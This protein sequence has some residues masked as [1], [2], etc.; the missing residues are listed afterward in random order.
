IAQAGFTLV[1]LAIVLL[2]VGL[3]ISG[4][5]KGQELIQNSRTT[6]TIQQTK[7]YEAAVNTFRDSF[8][9]L[10]GDLINALDRVPGCTA[11]NVNCANG[12]G[13][14]RVGA[15]NGAGTAS[16]ATVADERGRFWQ[17]LA[18]ANLIS[19][20]IPNFTATAP[21]WG[22]NLP[23]GRLTGGF[24]IGQANLAAG[25]A[26][27]NAG[28]MNGHYLTMQA[29]PND[30]TASATNAA[31]EPGRAAQIDLKLDD[32]QPGTGDVVALGN[33]ATCSSLNTPAG[34]YVSATETAT[35]NI[36]IKILN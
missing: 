25:G 11:A 30:T 29:I 28:P 22:T 4:I 5:L 19:G 27:G 36:A 21:A 31:V 24:L 26:P 15:N 3:L 17:H 23:A 20:V 14:G 35:C 9:G 32:G 7:S 33:G 13:N 12:D 8:G 6:A 10:P 2:I 34:V 18:L 1:E 16:G